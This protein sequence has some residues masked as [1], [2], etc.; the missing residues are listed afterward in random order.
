MVRS[1]GEHGLRLST[2]FLEYLSA[3]HLGRCFAS[4]TATKTLGVMVGNKGSTQIAVAARAKAVTSVW[5]QHRL[6]V[7]L[8]RAPLP[9]M[10]FHLY[11]T[12]P[13]PRCCSLV[14]HSKLCF[15]V[16]CRLVAIRSRSS[17]VSACCKG[18]MVAGHDPICLLGGEAMARVGSH[19]HPGLPSLL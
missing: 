4:K 18:S 6:Y 12:P 11:T 2:G 16:W 15:L 8:C 5:F 9:T 3:D 14:R 10:L 13:C 7:T 1:A 17:S 19:G